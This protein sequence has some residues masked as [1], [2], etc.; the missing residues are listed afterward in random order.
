[1]IFIGYCL[2]QIVTPQFFLDDEYPTF[3][4]GFRAYFASASIMIALEAGLM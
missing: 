2:G 1:M 3:P 4:T